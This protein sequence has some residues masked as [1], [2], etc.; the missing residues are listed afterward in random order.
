MNKSAICFCTNFQF[1]EMNFAFGFDL[2]FELRES[3][4]K[5]LFSTVPDN[6]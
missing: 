1:I 2:R 3:T 5:A 4:K 6:N